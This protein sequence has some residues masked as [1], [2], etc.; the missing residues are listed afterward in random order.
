[1]RAL[2]NTSCKTNHKS[3][4][5]NLVLNNMP[6]RKTSHLMRLDVP[7]S[8]MIATSI[9]TSLLTSSV[10]ANEKVYRGHIYIDPEGE[11]FY[12]C[13]NKDG[14]WFISSQTIRKRILTEGMQKS[15]A[16]SESGIFVELE[17]EVGRKTN[18]SDELIN[19]YPAFFHIHR[20]RS[21]RKVTKNDYQY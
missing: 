19:Q 16:L 14:Y 17:G 12:P 8:L 1:M 2:S 13:G 15:D 6:I 20:I 9:L 10:N 21:I 5:Q 11:A 4:T 3:D 7:M 18:V